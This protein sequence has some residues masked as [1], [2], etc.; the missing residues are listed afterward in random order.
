VQ[1]HCLTA[2]IPV[3]STKKVLLKMLDFLII[4]RATAIDPPIGSYRIDD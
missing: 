1:V 2:G 4:G 3:L